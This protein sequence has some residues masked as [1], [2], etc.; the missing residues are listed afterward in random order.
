MLLG[1]SRNLKEAA[2]GDKTFVL[3]LGSQKCGTTWLHDYLNSHRFADF[4]FAKEYHI[5]DC[6]HVKPWSKGK[7]AAIQRLLD[8]V[9]QQPAKIRYR[10]IQRVNFMVNPESYFDYFTGRLSKPGIRLTG[11]MTPA[12]SALPVQVLKLIKDGFEERSIA[13]RPLLLMRDPV[14]RLQSMVRMTFKKKGV[15]PTR[16]QELAAMKANQLKPGDFLRADYPEIVKRARSVFGEEGVYIDLFERLFSDRTREELGAYLGLPLKAPKIHDLKNVSKTEN[17]LT[18]EEYDEFR[19]RY[20]KLYSRTGKI[21]GLDTDRY[22][23][24]KEGA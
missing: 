22:W 10:V 24:F 13:V 16:D 15:T 7:E 9:Q 5:F 11:D 20:Q 21:T 1:R 14:Y 12:Y 4:G 17:S 3:C 23:C 8:D 6:V 2:S 18:K 19:G